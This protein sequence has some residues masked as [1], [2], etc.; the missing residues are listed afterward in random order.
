MGTTPG[1]HEPCRPNLAGQ[2]AQAQTLEMAHLML[3][4]S[5]FAENQTSEWNYKSGFLHQPTRQKKS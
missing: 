4:L 1:V 5:A 3:P 2:I